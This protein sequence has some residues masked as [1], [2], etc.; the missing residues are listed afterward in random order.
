MEAKFKEA[1]VSQAKLYDERTALVYQVETLKDQLEDSN[2]QIYQMKSDSQRQQSQLLHAKHTQDSLHVDINNLKHQINFR[3]NFMET[4]GLHLP[5]IHEEDDEESS[6]NAQSVQFFPM[7][8]RD[9]LLK[10]INNLKEELENAKTNVVM[11]APPSDS[12][13]RGEDTKDIIRESTRLV[14][15]YKNKLQLSEAETTRLEGAVRIAIF[16]VLPVVLLL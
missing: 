6:T 13:L 3:D 5:T 1:L 12:L 16:L 2:N 4:H 15:E 9:E 10:E 14:S 8:E 11:M 7:E